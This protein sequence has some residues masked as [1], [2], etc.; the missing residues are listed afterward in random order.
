MR[1]RVLVVGPVGSSSATG[2]WS[3]AALPTTVRH[4]LNTGARDG[5]V[6]VVTDTQARVRMV[7]LEQDRQ[8]MEALERANR[9]RVRRKEV[10][11][12][13]AVGEADAKVL[14]GEPPECLHTAEVFDYLTWL[15]KVG[16]VKASKIL[17]RAQVAPSR[18][19]VALTERERRDL[20]EELPTRR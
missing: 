11:E 5:K 16:K 14:L 12:Q 9:V 10:K 17:R 20:Q 1:G 15:P 19:L 8:R 13:L 3:R 4:S 18:R 7:A 2:S 6:A